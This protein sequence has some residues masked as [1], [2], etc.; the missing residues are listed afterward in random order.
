MSKRAL[1]IRALVSF[2]LGV[3]TTVGVAWGLALLQTWG[4]PEGGT[5]LLS[6]IDTSVSSVMVEQVWQRGAVVRNV[7]TLP[8][9]RGG[10]LRL[11][12]M[13]GTVRLLEREDV[14][15][16]WGLAHRAVENGEEVFGGEEARGWPCVALYSYATEVSDPPAR[17]GGLR[18]RE[19]PLGFD[20]RFIPLLPIWRGLA[21]DTGFY[22][23]GW[24][25]VLIMPVLMRG[26]WRKKR[27]RC[28][29]CGYDVKRDF[30]AGCH[31]CGWNKPVGKVGEIHS[32]HG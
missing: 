3:V 6:P 1:G 22:G 26:L 11:P 12:D 9:S 24:G 16:G 18:V 29:R 10:I 7:I 8:D 27:G 2:I 20:H 30:A 17:H 19:D 13:F 28:P 23:A 25:V 15:V 5:T 14:D 31:E 4:E 21:I 32:A